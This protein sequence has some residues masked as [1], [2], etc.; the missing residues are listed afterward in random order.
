MKEKK[1]SSAPGE[2]SAL[3]SM[4][5]AICQASAH[6]E[7]VVIGYGFWED[8]VW[9]DV[10]YSPDSSSIFLFLWHVCVSCL[11][12]ARSPKGPRRAR[13]WPKTQ[14]EMRQQQSSVGH[15]PL[16]LVTVGLLSRMGY[17][18]GN[19]GLPLASDGRMEFRTCT[20]CRNR[21]RKSRF[22]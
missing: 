6:T 2:N 16:M 17:G 21:D 19:G 10:I 3:S 11:C 15:N 9:T 18:L 8:A 5:E 20:Q 12:V 22:F 14:A 13:V 4:S 1:F 7:A